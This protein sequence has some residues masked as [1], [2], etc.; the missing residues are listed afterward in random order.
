MPRG[1]LHRFSGYADSMPS[2]RDVARGQSVYYLTTGVWPLVSARTFQAVTGPK[3]DFW[4]AQTAG[5]LIGVIGAAVGLA[6]SDTRSLRS[7]EIRTLAVGSALS[8][9]AVDVVFV[10]R[11]R[12]SPIYLADAA[13]EVGIAVGWG[14]ACRRR[15]WEGV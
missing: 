8:L 3:Q 11:R 9:A 5:A 7:R 14:I 1:L 4:L 13:V 10:A 2:C 12:I 6:A 15:G